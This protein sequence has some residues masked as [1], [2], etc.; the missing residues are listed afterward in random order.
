MFVIDNEMVLL[1]SIA[2]CDECEYDVRTNKTLK[3]HDNNWNDHKYMIDW[4]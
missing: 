2:W 1:S 3:S 4:M